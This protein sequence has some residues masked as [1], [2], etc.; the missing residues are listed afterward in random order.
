MLQRVPL[1]VEL[2]TVQPGV[3]YNVYQY[4][5]YDVPYKVM[6]TFGP[7]FCRL[8]ATKSFKNKAIFNENS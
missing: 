8:H 4:Y 7:S 3:D 1:G 6:R 5:R 2:L